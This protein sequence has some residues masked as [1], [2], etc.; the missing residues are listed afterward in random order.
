MSAG[1]NF[2]FKLAFPKTG[3]HTYT[4]GYRGY[5]VALLQKLHDRYG[6]SLIVESG[7]AGGTELFLKALQFGASAAEIPFT[8]HYERRGANSKIRIG[9][10]IAGYLALLRRLRSENPPS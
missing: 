2:L 7:F 1:A 3:V 4:N 8:L 10:T 5:R 6:D 9:R